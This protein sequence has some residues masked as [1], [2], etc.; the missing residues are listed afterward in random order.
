[1]LRPRTASWEWQYGS[2][3]CDPDR[4]SIDV[5]RR[6]P[7]YMLSPPPRSHPTP[8]NMRQIAMRLR[9]PGLLKKGGPGRE[10]A[11]PRH[12]STLHRGDTQEIKICPAQGPRAGDQASDDSR[13]L[14][15]ITTAGR[16]PNRKRGAR[17]MRR[18]CWYVCR[19]T[20][21]FPVWKID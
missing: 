18:L 12:V 11:R 15:A 1:M 3:H 10:A 2:R 19:Q 14:A 21:G 6:A 20:G 8:S 5:S 13:V 9:R 4:K 16:P 17:P 7:K